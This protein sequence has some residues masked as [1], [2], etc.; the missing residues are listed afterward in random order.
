MIHQDAELHQP[1]DQNIRELFADFLSC[2]KRGQRP[3]SDIEEG[4]RSTNMSLLAMLCLKLGRSIQW[5]G[6][7]QVIVGDDEASK[8]LRREYRKPWEY[9]WA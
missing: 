8:L 3:I 9:P 2:I 5:D 7:K 6:E 1:D 4:Y